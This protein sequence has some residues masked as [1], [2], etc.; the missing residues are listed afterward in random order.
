MQVPAK[1]SPF[2]F[3][4]SDQSG[5]GGTQ[6]LA[7]RDRVRRRRNLPGKVAQE[8]FIVPGSAT[9]PGAADN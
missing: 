5:P 8:P 3:P 7:Q 4:R 6:R 1:P 2:F 9:L